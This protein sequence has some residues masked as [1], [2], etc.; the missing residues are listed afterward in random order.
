MRLERHKNRFDRHRM[1]FVVVIVAAIAI[2]AVWLIQLSGSRLASE[3]SIDSQFYWDLAAGV[4]SGK[5]IPAGG[6]TFNPLYPLFLVAVLGVFGKTLLAVRIIQSVVGLAT[7]ALIYTAGRMLGDDSRMKEISGRNLG[8]TAMAI[9]A[10]YPQFFL[11]EGMLLGSTL[12]IFLLTASFTL[13]LALDRKLS[14]TGTLRIAFINIPVWAASFILGLICGTGALGRPNLFL[15]LVAGIPVW[16]I[17]RNRRESK[18]TAPLIGFAAGAALLLL[19]PTVYNFRETGKFVPVTTHGG[20]NFYIGNRPGTE[21]VYSPP[22]GMRGAMR[23]LIEDSRVLAEKETGHG[24]TDGEASDYYMEKALH[25]IAGDPVGWIALLARKVLLF[26]NKTEVHDM[27]EVLFFEDSVPIFRF[28]FLPYSIIASLGIIGLIVLIQ[29]RTDISIVCLFLGAAHLSVML[30]YV[31]TRYRLPV[32][33]VVIILAALLLNRAAG[34]I[35]RRR[36]GTVIYMAAAVA[37]AFFLISNRSL[38]EANRGSVYTYLGTYYMNAGEQDKAAEAFAR[39]YRIDP[40]RDTSMINYARTL[41]MRGQYEQAARIFA[42]A[43]AM[44]PRYPRLAIEYAFTLQ[45]LGQYDEAS[46]LAL[47]A[48]SSGN[49]E[50]KVTACKILATSAFFRGDGEEAKKWVREGLRISPDDQELRQMRETLADSPSSS[51]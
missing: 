35:S 47:D 11:Y 8:L 39:A 10:V 26:W 34:E 19:P 7:L 22:E 44:N 27:P 42:R 13:A 45:K 50:D 16:I 51:Q 14:G 6:L 43:Y 1:L 32:V 12:E 4:L 9:A 17:L 38:V 25:G 18:W 49:P 36:Y 37:A 40:D 15:L 3:L 33:P 21:G 2:R 41:M 30:F 31:N 46:R 20:I 28:P 48:F 5:G 29:G 24:M 23:G